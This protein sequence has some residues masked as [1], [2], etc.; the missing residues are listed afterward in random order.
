V[1]AAVLTLELAGQDSWRDALSRYD[2]GRRPAVR[3]VQRDAE[4]LARVAHWRHG[5]R[6]RDL[7]VRSTSAAMSRRTA[8]AAFGVDVVRLRDDLRTLLGETP[9]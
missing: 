3:R 6:L 4:R 9:S 2:A 7:A 1:D 5:R 8:Q